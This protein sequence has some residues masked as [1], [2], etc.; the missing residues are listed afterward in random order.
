MPRLG[1]E[2]S[3]VHCEN[4]LY[5]VQHTF[6]L[7]LI[8]KE[9]IFLNQYFIFPADSIVLNRGSPSFLEEFESYLLDTV[10]CEWLP[11]YYTLLK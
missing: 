7:L 9:W 11:V 3:T 4:R 10:G 1:Y 8:I 2:I 6:F 5:F